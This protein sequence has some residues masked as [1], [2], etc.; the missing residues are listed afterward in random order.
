MKAPPPK[1]PAAAKPP[2]KQEEFAPSVK[3]AVQPKGPKPI[4]QY[5]EADIDERL[6]QLLATR[7][8]KGT[9]KAEQLSILTQLAEVTKR[10]SKLVELLGHVIAFNFDMHLNMLTAM[11]VKVWKEI[12][13]VFS[14]ILA[15]LVANPDLKI[16]VIEG[17]TVVDSTQMT[18]AEVGDEEDEF[19]DTG[20][21]Q[22]TGNVL[23]YLERLDDEF[24][25]SLQFLDPHAPEYVSRLK[26]EVPLINLMQDTLAYYDSNPQDL[27]SRESAR[28]AS[29][30]VEH[31]CYREQAHFNKAMHHAMGRKQQ[32]EDAAKA[33]AKAAFAAV[34]L[35]EKDEEE[36][37]EDDESENDE[38]DEPSKTKTVL[39]SRKAA[40][41]AVAA[42]AEAKAAH[43][44]FAVPREMDLALEMKTLSARIFSL[45]TERA[46][47]RALLCG[48]YHHAL[49]GRYQTARDML[50][51]SH[52]ADTIHQF[53][54]ATQILYNR[55]L[56]RCGI[57]AFENELVSEAHSSLM[58]I[59]AGAR[60]K[61]L[62]AQGI[63]SGRFNERNPEQE[64]QERR[65]LVPYHMHINLEL[66][67]AIHL[68][69]AML[70]ELPN[71]AHN[72]FDPKR[73]S[74]A[75]SKTFRRLL[76]HFERQVFNGP[77]ENI[78][79][80]IMSASQLL[81][82]GKWRDAATSIEGMPV[83]GLLRDPDASRR[84]IRRQI[85]VEGV[86]SYLISSYAHYDSISLESI[87]TRF[88]LSKEDVHAIVSKMMLTGSE[89]HACWDQ[90]TSTIV[91]QRTEPSKL[92]FLALQLADKVASF[93]ETNEFVLDSRTGS[94]GYKFNEHSNERRDGGM[95]ERRPWVERGERY[96]GGGGGGRA[97][98]NN[99]RGF[100]RGYDRGYAGKGA[101]GR[102]DAGGRG[103]GGRGW[104]TNSGG[105]SSAMYVERNNRNYTANRR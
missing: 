31:I 88:E 60:L 41:Q 77:P 83:W 105:R 71:L 25:K 36:Q 51:M 73:R 14:R 3:P 99:D 49:H 34:E 43:A 57:C 9:N 48:V 95:R 12:F 50:L 21:T 18:T 55:A 98:Y 91:V 67:E 96:G 26:D 19:I 81:L 72:A 20:I 33:A 59:A 74:A 94:Y 103:G 13:D 6:D 29:R 10:P 37:D 92:Q 66:V 16:V 47:T 79:D 85:Q 97:W 45:S 69:C 23:S 46:K 93:V 64:K 58:E 101:G 68:V 63:S 61:E 24:Y 80:H 22:M 39:P 27:D 4:A 32:L 53:D 90:P 62:L 70:L 5:N 52:L 28:V 44:N 82:E 2:P 35:A 1:K 15:T 76:D 89:L 7:G 78:R 104:N 11:P 8:R 87:S 40:N 102:G 100:D 17:S 42:A 84:F 75:V 30:I 65:R 56:V 54:I 86:R 38:D